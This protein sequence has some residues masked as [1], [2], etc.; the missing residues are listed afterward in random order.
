[1]M[2][3]AGSVRTPSALGGG[4]GLMMLR[5]RGSP[6]VGRGDDRRIWC[7]TFE[8][9]ILLE[10]RDHGQR[11]PIDPKNTALQVRTRTAQGIILGEDRLP[12]IDR[13]G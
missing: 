4:S 3:D 1:M 9:S 8:D 6:R 7:Q 10:R 11:L 2:I 13:P 5:I 12:S